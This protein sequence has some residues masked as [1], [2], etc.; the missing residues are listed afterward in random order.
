MVPSKVE[1]MSSLALAVIVELLNVSVL[2]KMPYMPVFAVML[3][4]VIGPA[5]V[6]FPAVPPKIA[7]SGVPL[8]QLVLTEPF[9]QFEDV[10]SHV[11]VPPAPPG[12]QVIS[13]A[14]S[15]GANGRQIEMI[16]DKDDVKERGG[17]NRVSR[18]FL[19]GGCSRE[20]MRDFFV[21][22]SRAKLMSGFDRPAKRGTRV[23]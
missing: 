10:V 18:D 17:S 16:A 2:P 7:E 20:I 13:A 1:I 3:P 9:H 22:R 15:V 11:P 21:G 5:K 23:T 19:M 12:P 4:T 6:T 14:L 8:L